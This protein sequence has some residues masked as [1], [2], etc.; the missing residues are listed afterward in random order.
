M[1]DLSLVEEFVAVSCPL[2]TLGSLSYLPVIIR[3]EEFSHFLLS[4][5][6]IVAGALSLPQ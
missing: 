6:H 2:Q 5:S 1:E 3:K 4:E